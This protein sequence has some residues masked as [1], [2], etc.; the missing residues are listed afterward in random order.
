MP[1]EAGGTA[2][3]AAIDSL[4]KLFHDHASPGLGFLLVGVDIGTN[5][6]ERSGPRPS[7]AEAF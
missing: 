7:S 2:L 6:G 5:T 4:V 3:T 1:V